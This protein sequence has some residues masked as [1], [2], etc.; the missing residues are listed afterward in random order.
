MMKIIQNKIKKNS[1]M[2]E[3]TI[4]DIIHHGD[5]TQAMD[6]RGHPIGTSCMCGSEIFIALISFDE[7]KEIAFYFLDAECVNCGSLVTLPTPIDKSPEE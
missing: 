7:S 2:S 6:L 3:K 5:Y 4:R 1:T